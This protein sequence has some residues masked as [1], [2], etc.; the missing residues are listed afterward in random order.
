MPGLK[1][2]P[3]E[4]SKK[5]KERI[6]E[7]KNAPNHS[8]FTAVIFSLFCCGLPSSAHCTNEDTKHPRFAV[9]G[10]RNP[11]ASRVT[12]ISGTPGFC[13]FPDDMSRPHPVSRVSEIDPQDLER[14]GDLLR[15]LP[16]VLSPSRGGFPFT[17]KRQRKDGQALFCGNAPRKGIRRFPT[18]QEEKSAR[19]TFR[20]A[21]FSLTV[22]TGIENSR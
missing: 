10:A 3:S 15:N 13:V 14:P 11:K 6:N 9:T 12:L 16:R 2:L 22:G 20:R 17:T 21:K 8:G 1:L 19:P 5:K 7:W 18:P 4:F